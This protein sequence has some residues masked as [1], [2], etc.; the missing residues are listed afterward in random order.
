MTPESFFDKKYKKQFCM[1]DIKMYHLPES[2]LMD[3]LPAIVS[4]VYAQQKKIFMFFRDQ[5]DMELIDKKLWTFSQ[6]IFLPHVTHQDDFQEESPILLSCKFRNANKASIVI[7]TD[8]SLEDFLE[9]LKE[10]SSSADFSGLGHI[11]WVTDAKMDQNPLHHKDKI[12]TSANN[13]EA[14]LFYYILQNGKWEEK[15]ASNN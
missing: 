3:K 9:T 12:L 15:T 1:P 6:E 8:K 2:S 5:S 11:L 14:A 10:L 4:M 7:T 13:K